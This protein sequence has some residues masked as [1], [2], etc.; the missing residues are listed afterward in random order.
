M[1][2]SLKGK[3]KIIRSVLLIDLILIYIEYLIHF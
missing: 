1:E 3:I 2:K